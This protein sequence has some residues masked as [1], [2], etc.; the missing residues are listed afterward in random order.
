MFCFSFHQ[1]DRGYILQYSFHGIAVES[2]SPSKE[3]GVF[4]LAWGRYMTCHL[5]E[6]R[7]TGPNV[8]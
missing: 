8:K 2:F 4:M 6:N 3:G 5:S 1:D 7:K